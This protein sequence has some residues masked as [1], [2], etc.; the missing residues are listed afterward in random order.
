[1]TPL[2][3][4]RD[5]P[6]PGGL[7]PYVTLPVSAPVTTDAIPTVYRG[8]VDANPATEPSD[9][10]ANRL[11]V[12]FGDSIRAFLEKQGVAG[13]EGLD[14]QAEVL[15]E[16]LKRPDQVSIGF[17]GESQVGKSTLIN[18]LL[19]RRALPSGGIGPLTAQQTRVSNGTEDRINV[20]YH[21]RGAIN[22]L[23]FALTAHLRLRG[24]LP[25]TVS[26][27]QPEQVES[28]DPLDSDLLVEPRDLDGGGTTGVSERAQQRANYLFAQT[29]RMLGASPET[30]ELALLDGLRVL[31]GWTPLGSPEG[32]EPFRARCTELQERLGRQEILTAAELGGATAFQAALQLRAAGWLSPLVAKLSLELTAPEVDGLSIVDL[33]GIG[34]VGDA[35]ANEA[36]RFVEAE[37]NALVVVFR[38]SGLTDAIADLLERTGVIT[39][40]LFGGRDG[41]PPIQ[42][43]LVVTHLDDVA[44]TQFSLRAQQALDAGLTVPDRHDIFRELSREMEAKAREQVTTAL[45]QSRSFEGLEGAQE[46]SRRAVVERLCR[47]LRVVCV[48]APDYVE[49]RVGPDLGLAFLSDP[50]ATG[51]PE[52]RQSLHALA[53]EHRDRR[54]TDVSD[55][56]EALFSTLDAHLGALRKSLDDGRGVAIEQWERFCE[57]L[58]EFAEPLRLEMQGLHGEVA[59]T[60]RRG[61]LERID[62]LCGE[63]ENQGLKRLRSLLK[64]ARELHYQSLNAALRRDGVWESRSVNFP[65]DLTFAMVD[66]VA[67]EWEPRIIDG[68]RAEIRRLAD[69]D[70]KLVEQLVQRARELDARIVEETPIEEQKKILQQNSRSAVAWTKEQLEELRDTVRSRLRDTVAKPI[71]LACRDAIRAGR[72][73]GSGAK[74]RIIDVFDEGSIEA[75]SEARKMAKRVLDDAYKKLL[76]K[77]DEG[78]LQDFHDPVQAA[79]ETLTDKTGERARRSDARKRKALA[80]ALAEFDA[81]L[82]P[83]RVSRGASELAA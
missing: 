72:N 81:A 16:T 54:R 36:Q 45:M 56:Y 44:R 41:L 47:D 21:G 13:V 42:V 46:A 68:V 66:A 57:Q 34:V 76:R 35:A 27:V 82:T 18:A 71:E 53:H 5:A 1:M 73:A 25:E 9:E 10:Q 31:L 4:A 79:L 63:A 6:A 77:L 12:L 43:I 51:I 64:R 78:Y 22:R 50:A 49:K 29:R 61:L 11:L 26:E 65:N 67:A 37:G 15:R 59:G 83:L 32:V 52:L 33:P 24:L 39:K 38:N 20:T 28:G 3:D 7:G 58:S 55:A 70:L 17:I 19:E 30:P 69:R 8:G 60:L 48:A 2:S 80:E 74:D 75:L 23:V 14:R 40:L 62:A